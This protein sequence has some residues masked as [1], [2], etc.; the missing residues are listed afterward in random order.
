MNYICNHIGCN[1]KRL[2]Y[3]LH[4]TRLCCRCGTLLRLIIFQLIRDIGLSISMSHELR[5]AAK[6]CLEQ[7][8]LLIEISAELDPGS[9]VS[10]D[11]PYGTSWTEEQYVRFKIW[12]GNI[13]AFAEGHAS[14]DYR[15][16]DNLST[17]KFMLDFLVTLA[18]FIRRGK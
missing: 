13:G 12:A 9:D 5:T 15:L 4:R 14:L 3:S 8:K 10:K 16:R 18:D 6:G 17:H 11:K 7:F 1:H 2:F